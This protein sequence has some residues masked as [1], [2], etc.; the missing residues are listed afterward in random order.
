MIRPLFLF[1]FLCV[2]LGSY[3]AGSSSA[4]SHYRDSVRIEKSRIKRELNVKDSLF[5]AVEDSL[6][7]YAVDAK[8]NE[9]Q[10]IGNLRGLHA[11]LARVT[12]K[13][14]LREGKYTD[15]M[16]FGFS[17]MDWR[18]DGILY[19]QL[20]N[21]SKF[22]LRCA[23]FY[24]EDSAGVKFIQKAADEDADRILVN[25]DQFAYNDLYRRIVEEA[26]LKDPDFAKRYF[27]SDNMVSYYT[28]SSPDTVVKN[29]YRLFDS[30]GTKTKAY[31]L[32]DAV[33]KKE[34]TP[35]QADSIAG[36]NNGMIHQ[37]VK[38]LGKEGPLAIRS[39]QR[40]IEFQSVEWI[41]QSSL[42]NQDGVMTQFSK[43]NTNEKLTIIAFGYRECNP[44]TLELYLSILRKSDLTAVSSVLIKNLSKGP[45]PSFLKALDKEDKLTA[46]LASFKSEDRIALTRLLATDEKKDEQP[47][48]RVIST[49]CQISVSTELEKEVVVVK[50]EKVMPVVK[51]IEPRPDMKPV[52]EP[53]DETPV[54][55]IHIVLSDSS[56]AILGLKKNI[57]LALQDI[58]SFLQ[59]PY[60]KDALL[61]AAAVEPDEVMKK[62]DMFKGK[63]WSKDVL[64]EATLNAPI[65]ARRYFSNSTHPVTVILNYSTNPVVRN[66]LKMSR[67]A[68]YQSKLF[69]LFDDMAH[70]SLSLKA[71]TVISKDDKQLFKALMLIAARKN[72]LGRYNVEEEMNYY[73]LHFVRAINDKT[74]MADNVR[75]A[76]VDNLNC[77][78]LYYLMV[79]GREEVFNATFNGMF[80][81]FEKKCT[82]SKEWSAEHF[83]AYP[84]YRAFVALCATYGK[85]EKFLSL[86]TPADQKV[87]L[88]AFASGLD[89]EQDEL[90]EA[91]T[92]AETVAN[93]ATPG[94]LQ[95]LQSI[96]KAS[97]QSLDSA[98]DY[99]GMSIYGILSAMCK[100]KA[101]TDKRWFSMIAKKYKTGALTTLANSCLVDQ[102]PFIERM[103]F[104]DDEDGRESY[105]NF[106]RT[107]SGS[108]N[109]KIEQNYSYVKVTSLIGAR[110]EIYANKADLEEGG[111]REISKI[112]ADNNYAVKC[113]V[114]RGHSFHTEATLNRVP[115]TT[116][117]IMVGSC[118]GFYKINIALRK[119][120]D[121][122]IIS[123]R[124]IGVKEIN[125][126][127]IYSFNEY[128]RQGKDIN[129]KT[130]WDEMKVKLGSNGLFYDYVPPHKNLES[131][132]VKAYYEIMGG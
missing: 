43:F 22:A 94:I 91:A 83:T 20:C 51:S 71:A 53:V 27:H 90:S 82:S 62:I 104:Y 132:F 105:Q 49:A 14:I 19:D 118:G 129:W 108:P 88:T 17:V 31:T 18:K 119:A 47:V 26:V 103:Y 5:L 99:N 61:Y 24:S 125:D 58:P 84:H 101:T 124:Q 77:D 15:M 7:R 89:K 40:D 65:N 85:L 68:E 10:Q 115:S 130:F 13:D 12:D 3:A 9:E 72:Y 131:L 70:D 56:R 66:F 80:A 112:I 4:V 79:Y 23:S 122:Q 100:D 35:K 111:D 60:A 121:A 1:V 106:L 113:I 28:A 114:H 36:D 63:Y 117:F 87:L 75:F 116:R 93:T 59:K 98:Q 97:Y 42:W 50:E 55:P 6:I 33:W 52:P 126:P 39:L 11:F 102:K 44:R 76:S 8:F 48:L 92:V 25:A 96:I 29:I 41:R 123:T 21:Y 45:L 110:I 74:G 38:A 69:L 67:E 81:K 34:I 54:E 95:T 37:V 30:Y 57:Y 73:A 120:P 128:V 109:W 16:R 107:F 127:I 46:F 78:E 32:Y 2:S 64:E 86:F